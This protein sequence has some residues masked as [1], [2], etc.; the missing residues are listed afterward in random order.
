MHAISNEISESPAAA[1]GKKEQL[2]SGSDD[3]SLHLWNFLG[4]GGTDKPIARMV[5][6]QQEVVQVC[7]P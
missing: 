6:H 1:Q 7:V 2:V 5:G 4:R 3:F